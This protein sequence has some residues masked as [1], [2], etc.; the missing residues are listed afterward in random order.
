M[1]VCV[2]MTRE[3]ESERKERVL[4]TCVRVRDIGSA[5][6]VYVR[7]RERVLMTCMYVCVCARVRAD[8]V[9]VCVCVRERVRMTCACVRARTRVCESECERERVLMPG[10]R[11]WRRCSSIFLVVSERD[12]CMATVTGIRARISIVAIGLPAE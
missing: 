4:M 6:D 2:L 12:Q 8:D 11:T 10:C 7:D 5:D 1:C 9:C 3:G